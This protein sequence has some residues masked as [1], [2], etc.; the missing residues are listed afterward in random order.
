[1]PLEMRGWRRSPENSG[2]SGSDCCAKMCLNRDF[3]STKVVS[4]SYKC[5]K[6][7]FNEKQKFIINVSLKLQFVIFQ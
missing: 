3:T 7:T 5:L 1:M 4:M 6:V 2:Y